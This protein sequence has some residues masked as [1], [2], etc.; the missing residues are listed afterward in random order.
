MNTHGAP[1]PLYV[2]AR[3]AL[4]EATEALTPF[5][6]AMV[7]VGAQAVY[8]QAGDSDLMVAEYTTD[9]DFAL[10]PGGLPDSPLLES[11]LES[12]GFSL[13]RVPGAWL[14][15]DG[16]PVDFIVPEELA[17][18][19]SRAARLGVHG[20]RVA[21]RARGLEGALVDRDR[22]TV[23][24]LDPD[25]S[26]SAEVWVAGPAA[27]LVAKVTKISE[28]LGGSRVIDKDA[29]DALRL[30][31][32]TPTN[33]LALRMVKLRRHELSAEVAEDA[34]TQLETLFTTDL[35]DGIAM[36]V[37]AGSEGEDPAT[38]AASTTSLT[39]DLLQVLRSL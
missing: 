30:L 19:G 13:R 3:A 22:M 35:A 29:L 26:K 2:R 20:K 32:A 27:L 33:D 6:D 25:D 23:S 8:L 39:E 9:A 11:A 34:I 21:R 24:A 37:R 4:L 10:E 28:R 7:L 38:L 5:L 36:I 15:P 1:D 14:S 31:R 18:P 17:G 12:H 16:I